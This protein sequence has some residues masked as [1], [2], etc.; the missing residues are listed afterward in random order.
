MRRAAGF[1][2]YRSPQVL[3]CTPEHCLPQTS[4]C[5][6]PL[7]L[8]LPLLQLCLRLLLLLLCNLT[9]SF[10]AFGESL[11]ILARVEVHHC[12]TFST[13][14]TQLQPLA[15]IILLL[16][17]RPWLIALLITTAAVT[18]GGD[19]CE[20]RGAV[21]TEGHGTIR[22]VPQSRAFVSDRTHYTHSRV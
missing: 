9:T 1:P 14:T 15:T 10:R 5:C 21:F 12:S 3:T 8:R 13:W 17:L 16:L 4:R 22:H 11:G 2:Q 18:V 7:L 19:V 20:P 6:L